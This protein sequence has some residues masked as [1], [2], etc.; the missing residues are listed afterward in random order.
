MLIQTGKGSISLVAGCT[1]I[2]SVHP[3]PAPHGHTRTEQQTYTNELANRNRS[4]ER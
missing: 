1:W 4:N 2:H 3:G